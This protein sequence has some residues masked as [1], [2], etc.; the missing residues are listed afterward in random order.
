MPYTY[1]GVMI[2]DYNGTEYVALEH[3]SDGMSY[4][5]HYSDMDDLQDP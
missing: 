3:I 2:A 1:H 4:C 5:T